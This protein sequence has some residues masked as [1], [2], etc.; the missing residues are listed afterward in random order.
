[1]ATR[2]QNS[3]PKSGNEKRTKGISSK[4]VEGAYVGLEP[5]RPL[6]TIMPPSA[7]DLAHLAAALNPRACR[8]TGQEAQ[9]TL[10]NALVFYM[11][12]QCFSMRV[13]NSMCIN[14]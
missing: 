6:Q 2:T 13:G 8:E 3:E 7:M 11:Q 1:M 14:L 10:T 4:R 12:A 9:E 5:F